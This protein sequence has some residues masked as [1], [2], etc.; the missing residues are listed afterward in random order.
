MTAAHDY[1]DVHHL[2]EQLTPDQLIEVRAHALRLVTGRRTFVPWNELKRA[3][4]RLPHI[5]YAEFRDDIDS[6]LDQQTLLGDA[7]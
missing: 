2:V 1:D 6:A 4:T 3:A 5:D 7:L